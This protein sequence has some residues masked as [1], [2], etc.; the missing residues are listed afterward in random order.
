MYENICFQV[1]MCMVFS[2]S[3]KWRDNKVQQ[4][5]KESELKG[6]SLVFVQ[7]TTLWAFSRH[8]IN[9]PSLDPG[10]YYDVSSMLLLLKL[11]GEIESLSSLSFTSFLSVSRL[12]SIVST[13]ISP[14][15]MF[16]SK[17]IGLQE[18]EGFVAQKSRYIVQSLSQWMK[19]TQI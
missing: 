2:F 16:L 14:A 19:L 7:C 10:K 12:S 13:S 5:V 15:C 3:H 18:E 11:R 1:R 9:D 6:H 8:E 17:S 4:Q